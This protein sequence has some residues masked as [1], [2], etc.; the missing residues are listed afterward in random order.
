MVAAG[1]VHPPGAASAFLVV[2]GNLNWSHLGLILV[3]YVI[4]IMMSCLINNWFDQRQ[5]PIYW[6]LTYGTPLYNLDFNNL[7]DSKTQKSTQ[8]PRHF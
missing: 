5:Y 7:F 4:C 8:K 3:T 6:G 1:I 2:F